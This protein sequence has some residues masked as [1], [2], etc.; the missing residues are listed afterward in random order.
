[1]KSLCVEQC[2]TRTK[3]LHEG[4]TFLHNL[5]MNRLCVDNLQVMLRQGNTMIGIGSDKN[6]QKSNHKAHTQHKHNHTGQTEIRYC[7]P[8]AIVNNPRND[9]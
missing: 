8:P 3:P 9:Q 1:M 6:K 5:I 7:C 2:S 4:K